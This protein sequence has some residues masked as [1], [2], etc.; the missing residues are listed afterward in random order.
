MTDHV[1]SAL[2]VYTEDTAHFSEPL[3]DIFFDSLITPVAFDELMQNADEFLKDAG[4]VVV[5]GNLNVML[6]APLMAPIV[7]LAMGLL[8]SDRG[9][10]RKSLFTI[11]VGTAIGLLASSLMTLLF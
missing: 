10:L 9:L 4:H 11:A 8:R 3:Q 6:L 1:T 7:S 2:F 5:A